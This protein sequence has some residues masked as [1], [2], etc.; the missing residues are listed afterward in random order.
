VKISDDEAAR[1][2]TVGQ[3]V[4]FVLASGITTTSDASGDD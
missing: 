3:A 2:L 4:D 1:I